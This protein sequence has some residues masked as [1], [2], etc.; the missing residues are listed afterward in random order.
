MH[1]ATVEPRR[2]NLRQALSVTVGNMAI[3]HKLEVVIMLTCVTAL[4]L[5]ALI[6]ISYHFMD[7]RHEMVQNLKLHAEMI[8]TN[9]QAALAFNAPHD[10]EAIL[11]TLAMEPG[12]AYA[13]IHDQKGQLFCRYSRE[14]SPLPDSQAHPSLHADSSFVDG[15]MCVSDPIFDKTNHER[16]GS[17]MMWSDLSQLKQLFRRHVVISIAILIL[18]SLAA[19]LIS[20]RIQGLISSP[21]LHLAEV[22]RAVSSQQEYSMR[23]PKHGNDEVGLLIDS[24]NDMLEQ[25]QERDLALVAAN[26]ML[27]ARVVERTAK[28]SEANEQ[29]KAEMGHRNRAEEALRERT[30]R[31]ICH[32]GAL[33]KLGNRVETDIDTLYR[34]TAMEMARTLG[35]ERVGIWQVDDEQDRMFCHSLYVLSQEAFADDVSMSLGKWPRYHQTLEASRIVAADHAWEDPRTRDLTEDYLEPLGITSKMD[36]P[37]RL[38]GR[39]M[40]VICHEHTAS[41]R[42]WSLEEQDFAGSVADLIM[43]KLERLERQ[44]AQVALRESERRYRTLLKNI[45]QKIFYKDLDSVYQLC[46]E[47]YA[48]D[49]G[50]A[51]PDDICG[52]TDYD[53]H[54]EDLARQ[55]IADDERIIST[56]EPEEIEEVY[57]SE[58]REFIVRTLKSPV[59]DEDGDVIGIFGIFWDITER[60]EAEQALAELNG[61][62]EATV[63]EL[64]RSNRELQ[65]FAYVTAHDLKAPLRA[66]GTLTD[67]LYEDYQAVFDEQG[68]E[69]MQLV[70][71]RVA[72]MNELIDG[73]LRFSKIGRGGRGT[74]Q[75][76]L[77]AL[78]ADLIGMEDLPEEFAVRIDG[79]LP[80]VTG[81][82][83]HFMQVFQN[84][85]GNAIKYMDKPAGRIVI[86]CE[87]KPDDWE[88]SV[89]DNGPGIDDKYH[90]KIFKMFQTLSPRDEIESTGIGLAVVKKIVELYG[91]KVWVESTSNTGSTFCFTLPKS[92]S[93]PGTVEASTT[94]VF[95]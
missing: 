33:L 56:G 84:L 59:R 22:A 13:C 58:N 15:Y 76:D 81:E 10:A 94:E 18:T 54:P 90:A 41:P 40:A 95:S 8:G 46:N 24:F 48:E 47:S 3:R 86:R 34:A 16:I 91:G 30:E 55:Y 71:G 45:P 89:A 12:I 57:H 60:K 23:A 43:L 29:L 25:I 85:I 32:Q 93:V 65:D 21:I 20:N 11:G 50:L 68:R 36:V 87:E 64:R 77:A 66:I 6:F 83:I 35:V 44:K 26:E 28:L 82:R 5:A 38:H 78:V 75:V 73:I 63:Q 53:L 67:W 42:Q 7:A 49:L 17:V 72:R 14:G 9:C 27:E 80:A 62:L 1:D 69:Q 61:N 2:K 70:K 88:F 39:L 79:A 31:I 52:K 51:L 37:I 74:Q 92:V 19:F 4:A